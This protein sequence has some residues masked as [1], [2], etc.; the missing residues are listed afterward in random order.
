M[1]TCDEMTKHPAA[2]RS[3]NTSV[4]RGI[5]HNCV[6]VSRCLSVLEMVC[7]PGAPFLNTS[8][9]YLYR[10]RIWHIGTPKAE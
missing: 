10:L 1:N 8:C 5:P 6:K 7:A 4:I 9:D 3:V 2:A